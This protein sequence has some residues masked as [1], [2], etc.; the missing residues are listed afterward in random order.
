MKTQSAITLTLIAVSTLALTACVAVP[1][2][3]A[4]QPSAEAAAPTTA[5]TGIGDP[6]PSWNPGPVKDAILQFVADVTDPAGPSYVSPADRVAVFDNDGTLWTEKPIPVQAEFLVQRIVELAPEHPEWQTTQPF[7]AVLEQDMETIQRLSAEDV[8]A[9]VLATHA[10]MTVE[11]FEASA[12]SFLATAKHPRFDVLYTQTVYQPLLELLAFVQA[13][14]FK[15]F[16]VSGGGVD[17]MRAMSEEVYGI[18]RENVIGSSLQYAFQLT[19]EGSVLVRQPALVSFNNWEMKPVNI[20]LEVGRRP[21]LAVGNSDGDLQ[22]FQYTGGR[23][24]SSE[25]DQGL[26]LNLLIVHDDGEREYDYLTNA[27]EIMAA[28]AQ[29]PW[30]FVSMKDD[31]ATVFPGAQPAARGT[32][33]PIANP[34][35]VNCIAQGGTLVIE[36]RGELGQFGVCYFEDNMQCEEWALLRGDC[37]VGGVKVTGY[38]TPAGRYC[39]ITGGV[40]EVTGNSGADDEQGTCTLPGGAQCDAWDYYNGLCDASTAIPAAPAESAYAMGASPALT[41]T[42]VS[43]ATMAPLKDAMA[44]MEPQA[45]WQNFY[46]LT[47]VPRP[48]HH[49]DQVAAF[50]VQFGEDLG[51]ETLIDDVGN[52]LIRKPAAPG[53]EDVQGVVLQAHMDMVPQKTPESDHDFLTDPIDAY[54]AGEFVVAGGTTLGADDGIG[55]AMAMAVLQEQDT[56]LGLIEALF[57]VNEE[58]GMDGALGLEPGWLQGS[59]LINLDSEEVGVFTIGS[60][61]G[62]YVT[63]DTAYGEVAAPDGVTAYNVTVSGLQGGHSGVD[64]AKGRGHATKLL[65]RLLSTAAQQIG[66]RL[67][68]IAGGDAS[69]AITREATALVVVPDGQ[70][71]AFLQVAQQFDAIIKSELSAVEP[72]VSAQAT[73]ATLPAQLMDETVQRLLLDALYATPQ[74]VLRMSDAVPG[75]VETSTNI[76]I[77]DA[78]DGKLAASFLLRSS[79]DTALDDVGQMIASVWDMAGV[80]VDA[81]GRYAGWRP[82][83]ESPIVLLMQDA[84]R[85]QTGQDAVVSAVHAGL[86]CGTIVSKYPGMDAISIGPTLYDVHTPSERLEIATV[87]KLMDLLM[88][89][90]Q[91]IPAQ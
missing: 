58:D 24:S 15:S 6:L 71:D 84:Y 64:I 37:P 41:A 16:I 3:S 29:S 32:P 53:L 31:F 77:V 2:P 38:A 47:Q 76:G 88:E 83:P 8:E 10:G 22:M 54:V 25:D 36:E 91:R 59:I 63:I 46:D 57:T 23:S 44:A 48:S 51:L 81:S 39:A 87:P 19:P 30:L 67:A 70:V 28:T 55:V 80:A 89:T 52:V 69:N 42:A 85:E 61:G 33:T 86:E 62:E 72:N 50:L 43:T 74:G 65:V 56:P 26:F 1:A 18:P 20:Q 9:L 21:I 7:Q 82:N 34:A 12:E 73:P 13:H 4:P 27:E 66:V 49:E 90:L 78:A 11:E 35:S 79:V 60:A 75:L 68:A 45:V 17:F 14:D 5:S 40:Y